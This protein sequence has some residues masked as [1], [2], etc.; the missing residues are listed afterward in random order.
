MSYGTR[1]NIQFTNREKIAC[2]INLN[3]ND[4]Y[5]GPIVT[6][7]G[8]DKPFTL[9]SQAQDNQIP[10]GIKATESIVEF[11]SDGIVSLETFYNEDDAFWQV[12]FYYDS[13]MSPALAWIGFLQLDNCT[14][15]ITD[16]SHV[17][18]LN[19]N[20]G[21]A[22]LQTCYFYIGSPLLGSGQ[23][24]IE[25]WKITEILTYILPATGLNLS[26]KA[27]LNI[28]ENSTDDRSVHDYLTMLPQ[29]AFNTRYFVNSDGTTQTMY[30]ALNNIMTDLRCMIT[31][32]EGVWQIIRWGDVRLFSDG[33]MPGTLY[34]DVFTTATEIFFA[35][36][37]NIGRNQSVIPI[38]ENQQKQILRPYQYSKETFNYAVPPPINQ[39][40]LQ[41]PTGATPYSSS[42]VSGIRTDKY[43]IPTYFPTWIQR[44]SIPS[45]LEIIT[46]TTP[47][48]EQ[49][50]D[51]YIVVEGV[52]ATEGGIQFNPIEV[53]TNDVFELSFS[54][55]TTGSTSVGN[56][57]FAVSFY[58]IADDN[59]FWALARDQGS[60]TAAMRWNGPWPADTW[61]TT[62]HSPFAEIFMNFRYNDTGT[63]PQWQH[64]D[65][66]DGVDLSFNTQLCP[67]DGVLLIQVNGTNL[68][69]ETR[70]DIA[71]KDITLTIS[72][73]TN[74]TRQIIGQTH[75][76]AQT[77]AIKNN[78]QR[79][80][81]L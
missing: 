24:L 60:G 10:Y 12:E 7:S 77:P 56:A 32:A 79:I 48:P 76:N 11:Y 23:P 29:T 71:F 70:H 26:T 68:L 35:S 37:L 59:T 45:H 4:G 39:A 55:K 57:T 64:V 34:N 22:R 30:D 61:N 6:L 15:Q 43:D 25:D 38:N 58:V 72:Q 36:S 2:Q 73:W 33:T 78:L 14:E 40:S 63:P 28:F 50:T 16:I 54:I 17:I 51:R 81:Q 80:S 41:L 3:T 62:A 75:D 66:N 42:T 65:S 74:S 67:I 19:A 52:A 8:S 5:S 13:I 27:W 47:T 53:T 69:S 9:Q 46:D 1:Y 44:G 20:D 18:T 21:L 49:E 31:Q